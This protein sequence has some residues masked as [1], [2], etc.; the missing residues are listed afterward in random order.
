MAGS[1]LDPILQVINLAASLV[2]DYTHRNL[3]KSLL[4]GSI[5]D[6]LTPS[7]GN[8]PE[9]KEVISGWGREAKWG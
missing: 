2:S 4:E 5:M 3:V 7:S 8:T 6:S 9:P 1:N